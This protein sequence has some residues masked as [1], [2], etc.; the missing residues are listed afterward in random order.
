MA[1]HGM[2]LVS[3]S[4]HVMAW[5]GMAW[6]HLVGGVAVPDYQLAVLGRGYEVPGVGAPVHGVHLAG[7]Q[8]AGRQV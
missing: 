8:V 3:M 2:V 7:R 5:H 1:T 6:P 4:W